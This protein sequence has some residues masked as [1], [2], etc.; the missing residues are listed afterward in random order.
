MKSKSLLSVSADSKTVKG[1][2]LGYLTGILYMAPHK[3]S[4]V[5]L[6]PMAEMAQCSAACLFTAGRASFT[7]SIN[8]ARL[9]KA[10]EFNTERKAFMALFVK[11]VQKLL[12]KAAKMGYTPVCRPNGTTDI[13]WENEPVEVD[14]IAYRNIMEAFPEVQF[15]DY[16]K[17]PNRKRIPS[18]YHLTWSYSGANQRYADMMP[19][20]FNASVV[21]SGKLPKTFLGREVINGDEND[22]RFLD[23]PNVI[24]GLK[25]KGSARKD[26]TGFV[27]WL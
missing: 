10:H 18:N 15:M 23:P 17:I 11:D 5:N 19:E 12:R 25:A 16:T 4:G 20:G 27:V 13:R 9:R 8:A 14:G 1:E 26:D 21:F 7:P 22:L 24:V 3:L 2:K 6:C